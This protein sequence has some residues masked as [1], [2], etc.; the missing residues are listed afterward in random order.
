LDIKYF[1]LG[2]YA[3]A[4]EAAKLGEYTKVMFKV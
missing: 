4:F 1:Q 2:E 3:E